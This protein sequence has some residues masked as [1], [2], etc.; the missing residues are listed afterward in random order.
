MK[1]YAQLNLSGYTID[2]TENAVVPNGFI[3]MKSERPAGDWH[4]KIDGK[5]HAGDP[6][7]EIQFIESEG[8]FIVEQLLMHEDGDE[9]A[10][11]TAQEW[12]EYRKAL[13]RWNWSDN[14][15]FPDPQYRP[16]RPI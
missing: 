10:I 1:I 15:H 14:A 7:K 3:E 4:A 6:D 5:W 11:A 9:G 8:L 16:K 13:R 12:R 2:L